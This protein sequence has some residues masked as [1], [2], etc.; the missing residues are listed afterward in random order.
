M[1]LPAWFDPFFHTSQAF[2]QWMRVKNSKGG[3]EQGLHGFLWVTAPLTITD[4]RLVMLPMFFSSEMEKELHPS[5]RTQGSLLEQMNIPASWC[6]IRGKWYKEFVG[7][8]ICAHIHHQGKRQAEESLRSSLYVALWIELVF[9]SRTWTVKVWFD[10]H[11][12]FSPRWLQ[13]LYLYSVMVSASR[14]LND[15]RF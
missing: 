7:A 4:R 8:Q 11:C 14:N 9:A 3:L 15:G 2:N 13:P 1:V 6:V 5:W 12:L 10:F